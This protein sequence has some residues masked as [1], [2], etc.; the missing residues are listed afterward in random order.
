MLPQWHDDPVLGRGLAT[1]Q[2]LYWINGHFRSS[3]VDGR[4]YTVSLA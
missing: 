3:P 2:L 4:H 1:V